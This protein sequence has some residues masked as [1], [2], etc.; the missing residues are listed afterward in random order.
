[1]FVIFEFIDMM[2]GDSIFETA[3]VLGVYFIYLQFQ[4]ADFEMNSIKYFT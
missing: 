3:F 4:L 1:M 2:V